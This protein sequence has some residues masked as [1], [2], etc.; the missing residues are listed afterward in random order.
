MYCKLC[1]IPVIENYCI[2]LRI[3][4][5][6]P[7]SKGRIFLIHTYLLRITTNY[8]HKDL[9]AV[10]H[11]LSLSS[12]HLMSTSALPHKRYLVIV[13]AR[14]IIYLFTPCSMYPSSVCISWYFSTSINPD[15]LYPYRIFLRGATLRSSPKVSLR[16]CSLMSMAK[17]S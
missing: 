7:I 8:V 13:S 6:P 5:F 11:G 3:K 15:F 4:L 1:V 9:I 2:F 14:D 16:Y 12:I 10:H 17:T